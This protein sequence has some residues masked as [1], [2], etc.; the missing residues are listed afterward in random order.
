MY[1]TFNL[2][3]PTDKLLE[4][5]QT[6]FNKTGI[7]FR[8]RAVIAPPLNGGE[9]MLILCTVE[10]FPNSEQ[11]AA[12]QAGALVV[13]RWNIPPDEL[14]ARQSPNVIQ[15]APR[16]KTKAV[17]PTGLGSHFPRLLKGTPG[18]LLKGTRTPPKGT[19]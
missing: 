13:V 4:H 5:L 11:L 10:A 9:W 12:G 16:K 2:Q 19:C 6:S 3:S 18:Y 17:P 15:F 7:G 8:R 1:Q 14:L